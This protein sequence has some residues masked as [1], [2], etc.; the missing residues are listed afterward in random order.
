MRQRL[1]NS[2]LTEKKVLREHNHTAWLYSAVFRKINA[3]RRQDIIERHD[4]RESLISMATDGARVVVS[5][6]TR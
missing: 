2:S 1:K 5:L 4:N 6:V 3:V